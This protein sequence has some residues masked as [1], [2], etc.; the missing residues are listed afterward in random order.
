MK[1]IACDSHGPQYK[2]LSAPSRVPAEFGAYNAECVCG[3]TVRVY[4]ARTI[5][6]EGERTGLPHVCPGATRPPIPP[7]DPVMPD[8]SVI[9]NVSEMGLPPLTYPTPE[10]VG[11]A[12]NVFR[13][14]LARRTPVP[15]PELPV[16]PDRHLCFCERAEVW[17]W[18]DGRR[19]NTA[20]G[21][22]HY[23]DRMPP[24]VL[25]DQDRVTLEV[26]ANHPEQAQ[27][28][29]Q[30]VQQATVKPNKPRG[31]VAL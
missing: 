1:D 29:A 12:H 30:Q 14:S 21:S 24:R 4:P 22:D 5:D 26:L 20:D 19:T 28:V 27:Q 16:I 23:C 2:P 10:N 3:L 8:G 31:V 18:P 25:T 13:Q 9:P 11:R 6:W 17:V 15:R 7:A